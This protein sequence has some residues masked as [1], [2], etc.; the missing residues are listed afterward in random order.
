MKNLKIVVSALL[1]V[2]FLAALGG[3]EKSGAHGNGGKSGHG[4]S[5]E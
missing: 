4:H 1:M 3:C 2:G 5:H